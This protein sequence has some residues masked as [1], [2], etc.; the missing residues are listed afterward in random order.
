M[1]AKALLSLPKL[2]SPRLLARKKKGGQKLF[3]LKNSIKEIICT[4][5]INSVCPWN[6][7]QWK[8]SVSSLIHV[9]I[10][11]TGWDR[12]FAK[13]VVQLAKAATYWSHLQHSFKGRSCATQ[14]VLTRH[15]RTKA[16]DDGLQADIVFFDF[17]KAFDR[18]S[19]FMLLQKLCSFSMSGSLLNCCMDHL[20]EKQQRVVIEGQISTWSAILYGVPQGSLL[21]PLFF[22]IFIIDL[23]DFVMPGNTMPLYYDDYKTSNAINSHLDQNEFQSDLESAKFNGIWC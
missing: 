19:H 17:S 23:V 22:M 8:P 9:E 12:K 16:F 3:P 4:D 10:I 18:V 11:N 7:P 5:N 14:L 1:K 20:T 21:G 13:T 2:I 6:S 15:Q